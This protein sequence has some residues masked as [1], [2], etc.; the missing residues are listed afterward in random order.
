MGKCDEA[1]EIIEELVEQ[2]AIINQRGWL[3]HRAIPAL[4]H[5]LHY[6]WRIGRLEK[7]PKKEWYRWQR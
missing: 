4:E 2:Y 1:I 7:H 3:Y 6:L 5:A